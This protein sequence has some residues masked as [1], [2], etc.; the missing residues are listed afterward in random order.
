M[1]KNEFMKVTVVMG[2]DAISPVASGKKNIN[3]MDDSIVAI[4]KKLIREKKLNA[5][6][7]ASIITGEIRTL[8]IRNLQKNGEGINIEAIQYLDEI[9]F[10]D[11]KYLIY[12]SLSFTSNDEVKEMIRHLIENVCSYL[13]YKLNEETKKQI[14]DIIDEV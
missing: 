12:S 13:E 1:G 11:M 14:N 2:N 7:A 6:R 3:S 9:L 5:D 4:C 10:D 8:F